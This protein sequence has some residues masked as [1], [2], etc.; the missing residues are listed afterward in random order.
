[1]I[2]PL[3]LPISQPEKALT[4][5]GESFHTHPT[6]ALLWP[7]ENTLILSD[8]YLQ[9][10]AKWSVLR[11]LGN[12]TQAAVQFQAINAL[13]EAYNIN[14]V[15]AI[16]RSFRRLDDPYHLASD[17][18]TTLY[19]LQKRVGWT[20]VA[21]QMAR[22]YP[23]LVGGLRV[24]AHQVKGLTFRAEPKRQ[25]TSHEIAGGMYPMA[26]I[27]SSATGKPPASRTERAQSTHGTPPKTLP[28]YVSN[29]QR[30]MLP[31]FGGQLAARNIL[32][33]EFLPLFGYDELNI[34]VIDNYNTYPVAKNLL[35]AS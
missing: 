26:T 35:I 24:A 9:S 16:G 19:R 27:V 25:P 28:C 13:I 2:Q 17:D 5:C 23:P 33:D 11:N 10:G 1:M 15:I 29:G 3:H 31:A 8:L 34:E 12:Q 18:L 32:G 20:W 14:E 21:G 4:L 7:A 6:G 30:L 22:A